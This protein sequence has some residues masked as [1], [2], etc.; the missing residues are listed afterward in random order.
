MLCPCWSSILRIQPRSYSSWS[1]WYILAIS[2]FCLGRPSPSLARLCG[3]LA[4]VFDLMSS[5]EGRSARK[6]NP[7]RSLNFLQARGEVW[8]LTG[9]NGPLLQVKRVQK[10]LWFQGFRVQRPR[11]FYA[12]SQSPTP[13]P[14]GSLPLHN[15]SAKAENST[16]SGVLLLLKLT[17]KVS[18]S[19]PAFSLRRH[20]FFCAANEPC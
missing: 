8:P 1:C 3:D 7:A 18:L 10:G 5:Q 15:R 19:F 14:L 13:S 6:V 9:R 20:I 2:F 16:F 4:V 11:Y 12:K 17:P